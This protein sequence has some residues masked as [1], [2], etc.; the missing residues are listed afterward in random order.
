MRRRQP[1][2]WFRS[3]AE[4]RAVIKQWRAHY[5]QARPHSSQWL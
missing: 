2:E 5:N 3:H 1:V 4:A